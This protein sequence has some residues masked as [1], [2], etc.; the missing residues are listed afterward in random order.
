VYVEGEE[1]LLTLPVIVLAPESTAVIYGQPMEGL[2]IVEVTSHKKDWA[3][4]V[5][6][7]MDSEL[8]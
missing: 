4:A 2:V 3:L 7:Q 6:R 1:D 5:L 8:V